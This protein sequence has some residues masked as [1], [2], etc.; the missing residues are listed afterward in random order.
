MHLNKFWLALL[1]M[2]VC[3][4]D[5][6]MHSKK[7]LVALA[8]KLALDGRRV[9][10]QVGPGT[11]VLDALGRFWGNGL[12]FSTDFG[13]QVGPGTTVLIALGHQVGP[14]T[15]V[16]M[17]LGRQV[18]PGT[19][20]SRVLGRQVGP[21]TALLFAHFVRKAWSEGFFSEF[22]RFLMF[23]LSLRTL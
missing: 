11:A 20:F 13:H 10:R 17:A 2:I 22:C 18:C 12:G 4:I 15:A 14:G 16:L 9:G 21:G 5:V 3:C 6:E 23:S 7:F 19:A 8:G 1:L